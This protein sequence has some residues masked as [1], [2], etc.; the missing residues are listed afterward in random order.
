MKKSRRVY[1]RPFRRRRCYRPRPSGSPWSQFRKSRP[2]GLDKRLIHGNI[3]VMTATPTA[4]VVAFEREA[5]ARDALCE[6]Q[7]A[8]TAAAF[9]QEAA[10]DAYTVAR[11]A[12]ATAEA[13]VQA[14][15]GA[16]EACDAEA[17]RARLRA[18]RIYFGTHNP[19]GV[20][21]MDQKGT[22]FAFYVYSTRPGAN[23]DPIV[24]Q[25][26]DVIIHCESKVNY[27][28]FLRSYGLEA[29][30]NEWTS[31]PVVAIKPAPAK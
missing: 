24:P 22:A 2:W 16:W 28:D 18:R 17:A 12:Y 11:A 26:G 29:V 13:K 21:T 25:A 30:S 6:A 23:P 8:R 31:R 3:K 7:Q 10:R 20:P 27:P 9:A 15:L 19:Y 5:T 14:A 1:R 4:P